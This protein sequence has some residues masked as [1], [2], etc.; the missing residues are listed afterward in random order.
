MK[1]ATVFSGIGSPEYALKNYFPELNPQIV[2]A[3]DC[4]ELRGGRHLSDEQIEKIKSL[5]YP[6]REIAV[7][8]AYAT[9]RPKHW[10][11]ETFFKNYGSLGIDETKWFDDIRFIDGERYKGEIDL[12]VGGSPCQSF[13][14]MGKRA[15]LSDARGTLF[16]DYARLVKEIEPKVFIYENVPG[17]LSQNGGKTWKAIKEIFASLGYAFDYRILNSKDF[18]IPQDRRRLF[19][20]GF[21]E[22]R[23]MN[24]FR[25]PRPFPLRTKMSDYL[26][27][28]SSIPLKYFFR[29]KGFNFVTDPKWSGRA[30]VNATIMKTEKRN[31]QF[32]WN[33]DFVAYGVE[34]LGQRKKE[35]I[36]SCY[37]GMYKSSRC[38]AR[39]LT[40]REC[41]RLM[42]FG[43]DF[44][45]CENDVQAYKQAGNSI[46]VNVMRELLNSVNATGVFAENLRLGTLFSG[47]GAPEW[48]L[49]RMRKKYELVLACDNGEVPLD[50]SIDESKENERILRMNTFMQEKKHVDALYANYSKRTNYVKK[51]YLANYGQGSE[52][53]FFQNVVLL[54]GFPLRGKIDLLIGGSPCQSFSTVGHQKGLNDYRGNL[55]F[56]FVRLVQEISPRVFVYENVNGLHSKANRENWRQMRERIDGIGYKTKELL[57]NAKYYGIPQTR[58]R[59]FVVGTL[60][61]TL[62]LDR[63]LNP[64]KIDLKYTMKD[65]LETSTMSGGMTYDENGDIAFSKIPG[66]VDEKYVLT[67]AVKKYVTTPG[68][69]NWKTKIEFDRPIARTLLSTMG[70]HHRAGVDNYVTDVGEL[71]A[72]TERECLRLM[73]FTDDFKIVVSKGQAYKQAGN[74]MVVDVVMALLRNLF[75]IGAI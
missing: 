17:M 27:P 37:V 42:G 7:K 69:K 1:V 4:G 26:E 8:E 5:S 46:V 19:V 25:F 53:A 31:Q 43:D 41:H 13:S 14:L 2:F 65:F 68:T 71:R 11:K 54:N 36:D 52:K 48:A 66:T 21:K 39:K 15:G 55:F 72:L 18:G 61:Q 60:D 29:E 23:Y 51:T 44:L 49:K 57:L 32:N 10:I 56:E 62:D 9:L 74:S 24:V 40:P 73:G 3:C 34:Q 6:Q 64:K 12:F 58:N 16:Y 22:K 28:A 67:P 38:V 45:I 20:V 30:H 70:N 50:D 63:L 47:I 75:D 35:I 33:G 59:I